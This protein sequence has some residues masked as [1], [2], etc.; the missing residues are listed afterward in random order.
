MRPLADLRAADVAGLRGLVLDLDDTVLTA[1]VLTLDAYA[2]LHQLHGAGLRLVVCTGR[3]VGWGEVIAGQWPI[4]L[5]VTENGAI[6]VDRQP[7]PTAAPRLDRLPLALRAAQ[8]AKLR[9]VA[10]RMIATDP[11]AVLADDHWLRASDLTFDVGEHR[12]LAPAVV[13]RLR[14]LA[15]SLGARTF[16]SSIHLHVTYDTDDKASGTLHALARRWGEDPTAA[17]WRYAFVG[18]SANDAS[19]FAA[20]HLTFGVHNV[21]E[22]LAALT[23]PPRFVSPSACGAGFA[24]VA[25]RLVEARAAAKVVRPSRST[26]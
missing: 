20:F 9:A 8:G 1:G 4:D 3:S 11:D 2:A 21:H 5:A 12:R 25:R 26:S 22:H 15:E 18:D 24:E 7:A 19:C 23:V 14:S 13:A 10:D 6:T 16:V 17:R